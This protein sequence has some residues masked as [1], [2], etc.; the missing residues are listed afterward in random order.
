MLP[1]LNRKDLRDIPP[2]VRRGI[3]HVVLV[4]NMDEV[5][6]AALLPADPSVSVDPD[7]VSTPA[8]DPLE[9]RS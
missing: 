9:G 5:I 4:D 1:K 7:E 8:P 2:K 6:E 3:A